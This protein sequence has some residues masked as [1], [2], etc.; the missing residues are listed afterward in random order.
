MRIAGG[1]NSR[2]ARVMRSIGRNIPSTVELE[3]KIIQQSILYR[4]GESH[5]QQ[6][7]I[8][9]H[10]ELSAQYLRVGRAAVS[11][12]LRLESNGLNLLHSPVLAGEGSCRNAPLSVASL[13]VRM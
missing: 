3:R 7:Q 5:S 13:F 11:H 6:Y 10:L 12:Q 9:F 2:Y 1:K 8:C 4:T